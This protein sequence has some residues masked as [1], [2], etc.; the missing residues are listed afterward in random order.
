MFVIVLHLLQDLFLN[1]FKRK[2][3]KN[4][5]LKIYMT[6]NCYP[7]KIRF[8][9]LISLFDRRIQFMYVRFSAATLFKT[10]DTIG[11]KN[12]CLNLNFFFSP[13]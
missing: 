13:T 4:V 7:E 3:K 8:T 10:T 11:E 6:K 12:C 2:K 9:C 1:T 5:I